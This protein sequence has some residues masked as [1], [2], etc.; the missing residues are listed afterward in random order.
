MTVAQ[1]QDSLS[2]CGKRFLQ[3]SRPLLARMDQE[4]STLLAMNKR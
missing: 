3:Q 2:G 1:V 4:R